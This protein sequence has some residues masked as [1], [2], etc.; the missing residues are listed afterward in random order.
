MNIRSVDT[1]QYTKRLRDRDFDMVSSSYSAI[2]YPHPILMIIWNSHYIDSTHNTA[3]VRNPVVD[4]LTEEIAAN[5]EHPEK[6]KA[7]G[8]AFDRVLQWN[9]YMIPQ[10]FI[11]QYH[12][13]T[14]DKFERPN[15]M[16]KYDLGVD[17]WWVSEQKA[18]KLPKKR[19]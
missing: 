16:P 3:G 5:Q 7:I 11:S 17:T 6:L 14:W 4:A 2:P 15:V 18:Q 13:A 8:H 10:W 1:T 12:V 19:R 9:F